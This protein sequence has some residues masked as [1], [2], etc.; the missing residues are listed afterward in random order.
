MRSAPPKPTTARGWATC[1]RP[2]EALGLAYY[3]HTGDD[4]Y[5]RRAALIL[6]TWF[7]EPRTRMNPNF[8]FAQGVPGKTPGRSFG[9]I[10]SVQFVP[11]IEAIGLLQPSHALSDGD[12]T[13]LRAWFGDFAG[14]M[15]T[16]PNGVEERA[17]A[18]NHAI[19]YD[20]ELTEFSLFAG[21]VDQAR[22]V[23]SQFGGARLDPQMAADGSLPRELARTRSFHYSMWTLQ[24]VYDEATLGECVGGDL[25]DLAG[26]GRPQPEAGHDL[27][28]FLGRA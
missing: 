4:R 5:A 26:G 10:D 17:A 15:T 19:Y 24:A 9:I 11:V 2:S 20:L 13:V 7:V 25:W 27:R 18:N 3:I 21:K 16:S 23:V 12:M 28:R 22:Q 14:W 8:D 6:R 1:R